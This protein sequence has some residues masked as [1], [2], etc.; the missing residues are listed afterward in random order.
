M[1]LHD[2][3]T[4]R[5]RSAWPILVGLLVALPTLAFGLFL[6]DYVHLLTLEGKTTIA[7][8]RDLF[9]FASGDPQELQQ[10]VQQGPYP[11]FTLPELKVHFFR[12]LTS[13]TMLLDHQLFDHWIPGYH[14][15]SILWY[16]LAMLGAWLIFRSTL[17]GSIG[18]LA[19]LLFAVD[20]S[21]LIPIGWWSNRNA[22]VAAA[23]VFFGIAAYLRYRE[24][25]WRP[26][27]PLAVPC[28]A[29]GL[30][31]A[32]SALG[33]IGY[34]VAY[35]VCAARGQRRI[36]PL[37]PLL[38]LVVAYFAY[39]RLSDYGVYGSGLYIDPA[40]DPVQFL[41]RAPGRLLEFIGIHILTL[42]VEAQILFRQTRPLFLVLSALALLLAVLGLR[43]AWPVL[44]EE[45]R[46]HLKWLILG[47]LF[48]VAP[49]LATFP[50]G[51]LLFIPSL[52]GAA[53]LAAILYGLWQRRQ[54]IPKAAYLLGGILVTLHLIIAP[55]VWPITTLTVRRAGIISDQAF[56]EIPLSGRDQKV[57][58]LSVSDP[59]V[60]F[61]PMI[62][63]EYMGYP[64][65]ALWA[66][67]SAAPFGVRVSRSDSR[68]LELEII[69]GEM[70]STEFERLLRGSQFP[71][72]AGEELDFSDYRVKILELG[73][74][75]PK[76]IRVHFAEALD[77]GA[78]QFL[79]LQDGHL[80]KVALPPSG[81]SIEL[82][83][84]P[85]F[86]HQLITARP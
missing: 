19:L 22:V 67:L 75:G 42:P 56:R 29:L 78:Y 12:P 57:V 73:E 80:R 10:Y 44:P 76:K 36:L 17:A 21:H 61:Y 9:L 15:H 37:L 45:K 85:T 48:S 5:L 64:R 70:L 82:P 33:G 77:T 53:A 43:L 71:F 34:C 23:P 3:P 52:G 50:S 83:K 81:E 41:L 46:R 24:K 11:W 35:E 54:E 6:D 63:R 69:G 4:A 66:T 25:G 14:L 58:I 79:T 7:S 40:E 55:L 28:F 1:M 2:K 32:E 27:L 84:N 68:S 26:G 51:R 39:Y 59:F 74:D 30:L 72:Q 16:L 20:E 8:P 38:L 49:T 60:G 18:V 62:V 65:P 31:G 13:L 86:F 47:A